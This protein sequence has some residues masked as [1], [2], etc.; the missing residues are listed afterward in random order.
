MSS[1]RGLYRL[2]LIATVLAVAGIT[3][4]SRQAYNRWQDSEM[5]AAVSSDILKLAGELA[6]LATEGEINDRTLTQW[7]RTVSAIGGY[8]G[9][10]AG[11]EP[12]SCPEVGLCPGQDVEEI[13]RLL[14]WSDEVFHLM[15]TA[16]DDRARRQYATSLS[17]VVVNL[18]S[19]ARLLNLFYGVELRRDA[20]TRMVLVLALSNLV[21]LVIVVLGGIQPS[22]ARPEPPVEVS[23]LDY[24]LREGRH[25]YK[26]CGTHRHEGD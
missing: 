23:K 13:K 22:P 9:D 8:L 10:L 4:V 2:A 25:G 14:L 15:R 12:G 24:H 21:L 11:R 6:W 16:P 26:S 7:N 18:A 20:V 3:I 19:S 1:L 5:T 17:T